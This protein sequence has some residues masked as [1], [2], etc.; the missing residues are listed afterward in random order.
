MGQSRG[1]SPGKGA[2]GI[3]PFIFRAYDIRGLT[4][5][6]INDEIAELIGRAYGT[7]INRSGGRT[8]VVG[9]D[10]RLSSP[11]IH[12]SLTNGIIAAGVDVIDIG[13]SISPMVHFATAYWQLD[14]GVNVTASHNPPEYNG[15]KLN[16]KGGLPLSGEQITQIGHMARQKDFVKGKGQIYSRQIKSDY[17]EQLLSRAKLSPGLR[18]V[19]DA[20][21]GTAGYFAPELLRQAGCELT[22]LYCDLDPTFPHHIPDPSVEANLADLQKKVKET[23][24]N[25]GLAYD[26]DGDRIGVVDER[27]EVCKGDFILLLLARDLLTRHPGAKVLLEVRF[28]QVTID[29]IKSHGGLP[30]MYKCGHSLIRRKMKEEGILLAG[31]LSGHFYFGENYYGID[32]SFLASLKIMELLSKTQ[33]PLS[34]LFEGLP[35]LA[36]SPEI[37]I[38]C[39]ED[40]K[41]EVVKKMTEF[42]RHHYEVNDIDGARIEFK[43]GWGLVRASNT[44]PALSLRFE[45]ESEARLQEIQALV[46][47]KLRDFDCAADPG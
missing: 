9:R 38:P 14:G 37:R 31:E 30:I 47:D 10:S 17:Y 42:F 4:G 45:A 46:F 22:E 6:D 7:F 19:V 3:N 40:K 33:K 12:K 25:L 23:N 43:N 8:V 39:A 32:D 13:L 36:S 28:S 26:G 44:G 35:R 34:Q 5:T 1:N 11:S 24:S 41:F 20:G 29:D 27:G 21:N 15:F 16:M 18:V 2:A